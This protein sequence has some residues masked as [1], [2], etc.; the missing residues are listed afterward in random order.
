M[1]NWLLY[2]KEHSIEGDYEPVSN[3]WHTKQEPFFRQAQRGDSLWVVVHVGTARGDRWLLFEHILVLRKKVKSTKRQYCVL[4]DPQRSERF[5]LIRQ[6]DLEPV[7]HKL[8]FVTG[9]KI[10]AQGRMIGRSLQTIRRLSDTDTL[11]LEDYSR[12]LA[13]L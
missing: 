5:D 9:R 2:W 11:L 13:R 1:S 4:G 12:K 7:L 10:K 8:Q 3:G 6:V